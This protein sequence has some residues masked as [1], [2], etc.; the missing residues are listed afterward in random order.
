[1]SAEYRA[2][3]HFISL[4]C[5]K[6]LVD[7]EQMMRILSDRGFELTEDEEK[8]DVIVINSCCFIGDAK[9]ESIETILDTARLKETAK[10]K[11]LIVAGCLGERYGEEVLDEMPEVD[12]VVGTGSFE[13]IVSAVQKALQGEKPVI[14]RP[15]D[16]L[17]AVFPKRYTSRG[18]FSAYLKIA[19][20]CNKRCTY[21]I[22]PSI[23]GNYRSVPMETLLAE[24]KELSDQGIKELIL[25]AQETCSYGTDLYG[26]KK[27]PELLDALC[28]VEGIRWIRLLYCYPEELTD[29]I[30]EAIKRNPKVCH[31]LDMPIQHA[32]D[33]VLKRMG[34][35]TTRSALTERVLRLREEIP[36]IALRTTLIAGFPGETQAEYEELLSFV[37]ETGFDRLGVFT[38]SAEEGTKAEE[39]PDQI[40]EE[41]KNKR[42]D[43]LM[44]ASEE[45]IYE[46]NAAMVGREL[47][48]IVEGYLPEDEVYIAR[49]FRDAPDIDGYLFFEDERELVSGTFVTVKVVSSEG[50]DLI[51]EVLP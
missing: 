47:E 3:V 1:M 5:D 22:I 13:E 38:Y 35:K 31:Y 16:K 12:A 29:A 49:T 7:S 10:L 40:D 8:A 25:V 14:R 42:R 21:C 50:Y 4:G 32:S 51:G 26:E 23:R 45:R 46:R 41:T 37:Q 2:K 17:P 9:E 18:A 15:L 28:G 19:E 36:D 34:R 43:A 33:T 6:N 27:L 48:V 44:K 39:M 20:G 24:A 11:A 30:I